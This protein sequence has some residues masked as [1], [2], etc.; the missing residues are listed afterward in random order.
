[1]TLPTNPRTRVYVVVRYDPAA[2][3][4]Q[5]QFSAEE[6]VEGED[7]ARAE[8]ERLGRL[9]AGTAVRYF[10]QPARLHRPSAAAGSIVL[11][12]PAIEAALEQLRTRIGT[13]AFEVVDH[14]PTDPYAVAVAAPQAPARLAYLSAFEKPDGRYDVHLERAPDPAVGLPYADVGYFT[15]LD[16]DRLTAVVARHLEGLQPPSAA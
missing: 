3:E 2:V 4:P 6:V 9:S 7:L 5:L 10:S 14:W 16:V 15:D 12:A 11:K 13:A 1:M 8:V